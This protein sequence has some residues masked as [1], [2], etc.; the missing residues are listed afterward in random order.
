MHQDLVS[1]NFKS[2]F[3]CCL[4]TRMP[5]LEEDIQ[6]IESAGFSIELFG[7]N[8]NGFI[9]LKN[10]DGSCVFLENG[11]CKIYPLRPVGC[12]LYPLVYDIDQNRVIIDNECPNKGAFEEYLTNDGI[13]ETLIETVDKLIFERNARILENQTT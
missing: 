4:E 13:I 1:C 3:Q 6:R 5:L 8:D 2:C 11:K 12:K 10:K 9:V 7:E